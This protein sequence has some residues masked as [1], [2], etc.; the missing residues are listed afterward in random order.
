MNLKSTTEFV[1]RLHAKQLYG[2]KS[3]YEGHLKL[4]EITVRALGG[5][6][7]QQIIALL[8]DSV[9]DT[10]VTISTIRDMFGN[11][12]ALAVDALTRRKGEDYDAYMDRLVGNRD[13]ILVK[14]CDSACNMI[15]SQGDLIVDETDEKAKARF[16]KYKNNLERLGRYL[17]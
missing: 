10:F 5:D 13:A 6:L 8:H 2:G 12:V 4:V 3:Y 7:T 9:E 11:R 15:A 16:N 1:K 17:R 14:W